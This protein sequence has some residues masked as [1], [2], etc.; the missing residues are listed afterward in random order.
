MNKVSMTKSFT[1]WT[2][3][4]DAIDNLN[5]GRSWSMTAAEH[6]HGEDICHVYAEDDSGAPHIVATVKAKDHGPLELCPPETSF[7]EAPA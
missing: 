3:M 2:A 4:G 5:P 6:G 7:S 1:S